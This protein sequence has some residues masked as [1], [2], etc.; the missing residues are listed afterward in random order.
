[1][2]M[3]KEKKMAKRIVQFLNKRGFIAREHHSKTSKSIYIKIDNGAIP[4][5][6][7]SDHKRVNG[8]NCKYNVIKD[9]KGPQYEVINGKIKKYYTFKNLARLVT[10]IELERHNKI[11]SLGYSKYKNILEGKKTSSYNKYLKAA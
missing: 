11:M 9:Y 4:V 2:F 3:N 5:I 6:R 7:V 1:M 10:D 8:D